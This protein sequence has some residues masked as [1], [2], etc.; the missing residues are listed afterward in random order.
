MGMYRTQTCGELHQEMVGER[1]ALSGWV[2]KVRD[3]GAVTFVDLRDRYGITQVVFDSRYTFEESFALSKKLG[4][5]YVICIEGDVVAREKPNKKISTGEIEVQ[6][7]KLQILSEAAVPPFAI[8]DT[9]I[10]VHEDLRLA[11][12]YLDM[13]RGGIIPNLIVRHTVMQATRRVLSQ[14]G[15]IEVTTPL[16]SKSTPEGSRDYLIPSRIHP[17]QLYALPQS[18]QMFK[19]LL[20]V[21]GLDK[22]F[23]VAACCR[24]EDLRAD[25]QPEFHQI[26]MEMSFATREQLFAVIE[27]LMQTIFSECADVT[28]PTSFPILTHSEC[29][30]RYGSDKPDIR[31]AMEIVDVTDLAESTTSAVFSEAIA[32]EGLVR[33]INVEGGARLTR[34]EIEVYQS[35]VMQFGFKGI[36]WIKLQKDGL[37]GA[38]VKYIPEQEHVAWIE[39]FAMQE[40]DCIMVLSGQK[41]RLL[42]ALDQ[43][44]RKIAR[45]F[46]LI[47]P[48]SYAPLWVV[49]FP[50]FTWDEQEQKIES[51]THPF[52]APCAEDIDELEAHPLSVRSTGYDLV[53]NG[54]EIASGSERIYDRKVQERVFSLLGLSEDEV[55]DRFGFFV[56]ALTFGTPPHLGAALGLDRLV[57]ILTGTENIKDVIAFPKNHWAQDLMTQAPSCVKEAQLQELGIQTIERS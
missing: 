14:E 45:D 24:D 11:Y 16:L 12:R 46:D 17:G 39:R 49:D 43:L 22:Y 56:E 57:M 6:V 13:R 10:D 41:K 33:G 21:G 1:V 30:D 9:T 53:L 34:K 32:A 19:Q 29:M 27:K 7:E 28:L 5:E 26:D 8:A 50:L 55:K 38:M 40:G 20:M 23:Q 47:D 42:Q 51:E 18:P 3:F 25:R 4:H 2:H 37:Q 52:T 31:F 48:N 36:A 54:Y 15:F 35:L 44:R